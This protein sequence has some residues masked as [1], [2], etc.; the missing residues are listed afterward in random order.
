MCVFEMNGLL[1]S[2]TPH[3][4]LRHRHHSSHFRPFLVSITRT[5]DITKAIVHV[6]SDLLHLVCVRIESLLE[7]EQK[8]C[9]SPSKF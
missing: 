8:V 7:I 3:N 1:G 2:P 6:F 4:T 9:T 5:W